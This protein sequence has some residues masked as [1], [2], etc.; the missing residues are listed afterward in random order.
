[1]NLEKLE[2]SKGP[3]RIILDTDTYN[4]V[5]DQFALAQMM[6]SPEVFDVQ[7]VTA[8]PFHNDRSTGPED[9]MEKSYEE[10]LRLLELLKW[11]G[12]PESFVF[13]GSRQY[14]GSSMKPVESPAAKFIVEKAMSSKETLYV[15]AIGAPTNVASALLMEP[16]IAERIVV[17]W[18]G[19]NPFSWHRAAEFNLQQ[20]LGASRTLFDSKAPLIVIPC[21]NVAEHLLTSIPELELHLK[22]KSPLADYLFNIVKDYNKAKQ[23][24]WSKVIWDIAVTSL[25]VNPAWVPCVLSHSP[26]LN[27]NLTFSHSPHRHLVKEAV[28]VNRDAILA[29]VFQKLA[30]A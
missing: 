1:M 10:I 17:V 30:K 20:D 24:V 11:K 6:L 28:G 16:K 29:D 7:G 8:A 14:I 21:V 27:D 18:L 2:L 19:G 4:E 9:G 22:G 13:R 12:K 26:I 3:Y 25:F 23:A 5:D 15:A